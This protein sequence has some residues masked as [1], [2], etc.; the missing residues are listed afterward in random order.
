[1]DTL[2]LEDGWTVVVDVGHSQTVTGIA[3]YEDL[4]ITGGRDGQVFVRGLDGFSVLP[5]V[6]VAPVTSLDV[7]PD[8]D[9]VVIATERD[10]LG[11]D[12]DSGRSEVVAGFS[13]VL[14]A[15][16]VAIADRVLLGGDDGRVRSLDLE[17]PADVVAALGAPVHAMAGDRDVVAVTCLDGSVHLLTPDGA[18]QWS[19]QFAAGEVHA[20]AVLDDVIIVGGSGEAA[21]GGVISGRVRALAR[22]DGTQT[23]LL[24]LP[25]Y[26]EALAGRGSELTVA[27][28]DGQVLRYSAPALGEPVSL[29]RRS[30]MGVAR[31]R[32]LDDGL[33]LG[34]VDGSVGRAEDGLELPLARSGATRLTVREDL[35]AGVSAD[36]HGL[37]VWDLNAGTSR[38]VGAEGAWAVSYAGDDSDDVVV[39]FL[40]GRMELRRAPDLVDVAASVHLDARPRQLAYAGPFVLVLPGDGMDGARMF[41]PDDLSEQPLIDIA[42]EVCSSMERDGFAFEGIGPLSDVRAW[43]V[44]GEELAVE[45]MGLLAVTPG[46]REVVRV[47]DGDAFLA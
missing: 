39:A 29:G 47:W 32:H 15:A 25:L 27:L 3:R 20:V 35:R 36:G 8:T 41:D 21:G 1:M 38:R 6:R 26:V 4:V 22:S 44:E 10:V 33:W 12:L 31:L 28:A 42:L 37:T 11:L 14:V 40:D 19:V 46:I 45:R 16:T 34:G 13:G 9:V 2:L 7:L 5:P 24:D 23:A 18:V 43:I 17:H 30:S